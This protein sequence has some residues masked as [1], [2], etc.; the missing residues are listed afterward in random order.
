LSRG[1]SAFEQLASSLVDDALKTVAAKLGGTPYVKKW[2]PAQIRVLYL[3]LQAKEDHVRH[4][5][6][7]VGGASKFVAKGTV[8]KERL[9]HISP[10]N[11]NMS[12]WDILD[13]V[14]EMETTLEWRG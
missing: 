10:H 5:D 4:Y 1:K 13:T 11:I 6:V 14:E 3:I 2:Q 9:E 7:G 8:V 12:K